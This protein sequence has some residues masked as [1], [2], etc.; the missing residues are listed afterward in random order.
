MTDNQLKQEPVNGVDEQLLPKKKFNIL[1]YL[2]DRV[3][4]VFNMNA[5]FLLLIALII[6]LANFGSGTTDGKA[7]DEEGLNKMHFWFYITTVF[8]L[9]P[10]I[11]IYCVFEFYQRFR[12][13]N[14]VM[15]KYLPFMDN[16]FG[17][18]AYIMLFTSIILETA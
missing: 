2:N 17:D 11:V 3:L 13:N 10:G 9:L 15:L 7:A 1:E 14:N 18:A 6:R 8:V 12:P 16:N 4:F 5:Q